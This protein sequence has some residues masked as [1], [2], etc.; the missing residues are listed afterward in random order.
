MEVAAMEVVGSEVVA[1]Q[2]VAGMEA[3]ALVAAVPE[4]VG[5]VAVQ[6]AVDS[7]L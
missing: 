5:S 3:V 1:E 6:L 2:V 7:D 4:E